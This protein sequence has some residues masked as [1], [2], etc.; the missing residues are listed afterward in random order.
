MRSNSKIIALGGMLSALCVVV[1]SMGTM[2]PVNTYVCPMICIF[3]VQIMCVKCG[4]KMALC[5]YGAVAVLAMILAPDKEAVLV[6]A[7]L[8]YYPV[9]KPVLDRIGNRI[10]RTVAKIGVFSGGAVGVYSVLAF[11]LGLPLEETVGLSGY[12]AVVFL[13]VWNWTFLMI[14]WILGRKFVFR[15]K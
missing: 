7:F 6:F 1:M 12:L 10:I 15:R 14:D 4:G 5:F 2:I 13:V 11:V 9:L 3:A 8:G